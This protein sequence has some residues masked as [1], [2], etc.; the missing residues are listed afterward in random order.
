[1][2]GNGLLIRPAV[3][4]RVRKGELAATG[5]GEYGLQRFIRLTLGVPTGR[6]PALL[7]PH[8]AKPTI[9]SPT[10]DPVL[11][12]P[13][14]AP[15]A[16]TDV[17]APAGSR[18]SHQSMN[19]TSVSARSALARMCLPDSSAACSVPAMSSLNASGSAA[20]VAA[21]S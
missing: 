12:V 20:M 3:A 13:L 21:S 9:E 4:H 8:R 11:H 1:P 10:I 2:L 16:L 17:D 18:C 19:S 6:R 5:I 7:S 14:I 15:L